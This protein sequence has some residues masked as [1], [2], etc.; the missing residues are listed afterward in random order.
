MAIWADDKK[1]P[2]DKKTDVA[3]AIALDPNLIAAIVGAVMTSMKGQGPQFSMEELGQTIGDAVA[4]GIGKT[5]RRKVTFGEYQLTGHSPFHPKPIAETPTLRRRCWQNGIWMVPTT[6]FDREIVLLNQI[7]HSGRYVN[8][9]VEVILRNEGADEEI[10]V[11]FPNKGI[12]DQLMMKGY[13]KNFVDMLEQIAVAQT[14]DRA[15]KEEQEAGKKARPRQ[16]FK[17]PAAQAAE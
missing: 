3:A 8:R 1:S 14:E 15:E 4:L 13:A 16:Y 10:D 9:L 2:E 17:N 6:L 11:R 12:D 5:T 7:T